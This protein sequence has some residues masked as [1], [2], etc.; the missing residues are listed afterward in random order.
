M[1]S[2]AD[3]KGD[4]AGDATGEVSGEVSGEVCG[5]P[6]S[7]GDPPHPLLKVAAMSRTPIHARTLVTLESMPLDGGRVRAAIGIKASMNHDE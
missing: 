5:T 6:D 7:G 3:R 2:M 4:A 1:R